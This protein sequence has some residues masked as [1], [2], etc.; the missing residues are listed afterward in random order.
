MKRIKFTA[1]TEFEKFGRKHPDNPV[2]EEGS[3]H[4]MR[5][6]QAD[7]WL[8]RKAAELVEDFG[9]DEIEGVDPLLVDEVERTIENRSAEALEA[10]ADTVAA[11]RQGLLNAIGD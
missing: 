4:T 8:K 2:F 1:R 11:A 9:S 10:M 5:N 3:E 6:D 7:R